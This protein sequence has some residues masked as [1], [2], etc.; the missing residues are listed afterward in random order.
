MDFV[1][2]LSSRRMFLIFVAIFIFLFFFS[3][4]P[5]HN[6]VLAKS[7]SISACKTTT[8]VRSPPLSYS[9]AVWVSVVPED[10]DASAH[11]PRLLFSEHSGPLPPFLWQNVRRCLQ[12]RRIAFIG[13]SLSRNQYLNLA[14][15][16]AHGSWYSEPP[17]LEH[18]SLWPSWAVFHKGAA[19]RLTTRTSREACDCFRASTPYP[20][21]MDSSVE[22]RFFHDT[23]LNFSMS[24]YQ[25]FEGIP[26][27]GIDPNLLI[28]SCHNETGCIQGGCS[29]GNC[30]SPTWVANGL[31][32]LAEHVATTFRPETVIINSGIWPGSSFAT[33]GRIFDL[34]TTSMLFRKHGAQELI[35]KTTTARGVGVSAALA[36]YDIL[37]PAL[38]AQSPPWRIFD[39]FAITI[40]LAARVREG[41]LKE[42]DVYNNGDFTHFRPQ[43]YRGLN[44]AL[45]L[46]LLREC[47]L[48]FL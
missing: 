40:P 25:L 30:S 13:D 18:E 41:S 28:L 38:A 3:T 10:Q 27:R 20:S 24:F 8:T 1:S 17:A 34:E 42:S 37:L 12:G 6:F 47:E 35:W 39:A 48:C 29:P 11:P 23:E 7:I 31:V 15:F 44:E 22:N 4:V 32:Q 43:I 45:L 46:D 2:A 9:N 5:E 36:E 19:K 16:I 33:P 14:H 21:N 26:T